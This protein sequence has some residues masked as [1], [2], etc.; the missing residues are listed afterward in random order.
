M[1]H[2]RHPFSTNQRRIFEVMADGGRH[3][4]QE[5]YQRL[6]FPRR[7]SAAQTLGWMGRNGYIQLADTDNLVVIGPDRTDRVY[8]LTDKGRMAA[9][10]LD[11]GHEWYF[12]EPC[13]AHLDSRPGAD[14]ASAGPL[15]TM[16]CVAALTTESELVVLERSD[17]PGE[18]TLLHLPGRAVGGSETPAHAA[19]HALRTRTGY[20]A[21]QWTSLGTVWP[22]PGSYAVQIHRFLATGLT[23]QDRNRPD[24]TDTPAVTV[25]HMSIEHAATEATVA[26]GRLRCAPSAQL[27]LTLA[28]HHRPEPGDIALELLTPITE[29]R[30]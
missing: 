8:M 4:A 16:V 13:P 22:L 10:N 17:Y 19:E 30:R 21:T 5:L 3:W 18:P 9:D 29:T 14:P 28:R 23:E 27:V 25:R 12:D 26:G 7:H 6:G 1:S 15:I 24:D 11:L 2:G 20:T